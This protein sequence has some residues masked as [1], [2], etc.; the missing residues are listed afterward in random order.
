MRPLRF[1]V[2]D[3][4]SKNIILRA[5]KYLRNSTDETIKNI[6]ITPDLTKQQQ[7]EAYKLRREK[8]QREDEGEEN[9]LKISLDLGQLDQLVE[10]QHDINGMSRQETF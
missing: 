9:L 4:E 5:G 6:F 3:L 10:G 1:K 2:K 8:K 7:D